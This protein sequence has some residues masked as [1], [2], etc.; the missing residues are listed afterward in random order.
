ML[1]FDQ[2]QDAAL[3]LAARE[4]GQLHTDSRRVQAGD[5]FI[6]WPGASTDARRHVAAA[7]AQG[8]AACLVEA[9]GVEAF[10]FGGAPVAAYPGL[11]AASG[12]IAAAFLGE[13]SA[14]LD[15]V[16]VTGTNGK[17]T[18]AW[19]LAQALSA[20]RPDAGC[21]VVGTLGVG[22][23]PE[24]QGLGLTTPD[25]VL[26]QSWFRRFADQ[27]LSACAIEASSIGIVEQR[28]AGTRI[29]VA[30]FTNFSRDHLD[31][32][33]DMEAYWAAKAELF[34]WP[35][36]QAA[37][38]NI[39]DERGA[40]LA[41]SLAAARLDLWTVSCRTAARL[42]A[43]SIEHGHEGLAFEVVE[44]GQ[45][46]P[47]ATR[48]IGDYNISNL[49]GVI[50]AMRALGVALPEAVR[51]CAALLPVPG[52]ME[53]L[54]AAGGPLV[55]VDYAHTPDALDQALAALRPL[56]AA[57]GG[58]LWC[59][60]GCGGDRDA[61]K[62]P[63]MAAI[64]EKHADRVVVTSDNPRSEKPE[65]IISQI[66]LGLSHREAVE[67]DADRARAI[68]GA[69]AAADAR[70]LILLAGKGHETFQEVAGTRLPFDDREHARAALARR[71][72]A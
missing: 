60:F 24:V 63:L 15:V 66:L 61:T 29:R 38:L 23:P 6:A 50:G 7:L 59:V 43:E 10:D 71:A 22:R 42:R 20:A 45:R 11:K 13:P 57:R 25:A 1:R 39:D 47:L 14:R 55:A 32:H 56:A 46:V 19:W 4:C 72:A 53:V 8:A 52:R 40:A 70:D 35:G 17:T 31:Y 16:A 26:L 3:W 37:V 41:D 28:L 68:A 48:L 30:V 36:L 54:R 27:G 44:D 58:R 9:E 18:T 62:R 5:G 65:N 51:A 2:P 33:G 34:R 12:P 21:G 67:V 69:V 64:A 49:L